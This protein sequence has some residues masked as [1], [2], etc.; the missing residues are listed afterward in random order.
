[1]PGRHAALF[2]RGFIPPP[3]PVPSVAIARDARHARRKPSVLRRLLSA[4][5]SKRQHPRR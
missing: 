5:W 4:L 3:L 2:R 1:M